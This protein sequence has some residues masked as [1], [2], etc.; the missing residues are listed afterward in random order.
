LNS[1]SKQTSLKQNLKTS[2]VTNSPWCS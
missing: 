1:I 2:N